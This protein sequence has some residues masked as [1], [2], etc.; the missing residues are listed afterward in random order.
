MTS[1]SQKI[2]IQTKNRDRY[3][4]D[5]YE[6]S[7]SFLVP[8]S[9]T[10]RGCTKKGYDAS[11]LERRILSRHKLYRNSGKLFEGFAW[12]DTLQDVK[13]EDLVHNLT[14]T[15]N[16]LCTLPD[17]K[18]IFNNDWI[19]VFT[20]NLD[21]VGRISELSSDHLRIS[22]AKVTIPRG[23]V[24]CRH[25]QHKYRIYL[26][27]TLP[28]V[29]EHHN[30]KQFVKTYRKHIFQSRVFSEWVADNWNR[31]RPCEFYFFFETNDLGLEQILDLMVP[32]IKSRVCRIISDK[33]NIKEE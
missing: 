15:Y 9:A 10:L 14:E 3:F 32:G 27:H 13:S 23:Y 2:K 5:R 16:F 30:M 28:T 4:F 22:Q 17:T 12:I 6:Y 33:Y 8:F 18:I 24:T 31:Y 25:S 21:S 29:E 1:S 7:I 20:H 11:N 19:N 26:R